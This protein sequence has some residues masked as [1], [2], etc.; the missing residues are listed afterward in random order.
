LPTKAKVLLPPLTYSSPSPTEV[1]PCPR[2]FSSRETG[3]EN[4]HMNRRSSRNTI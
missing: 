2:T 1:Y 4:T 3:Q